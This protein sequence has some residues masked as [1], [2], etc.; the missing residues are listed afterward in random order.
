MSPIISRIVADLKNMPDAPSVNDALLDAAFLFEKARGM[1][2]SG[3]SDEV[4]AASPDPEEMRLLQ[5]SVVD[6]VERTGV[7]SWTLGKCRDASLKPVLLAV[8]RRQLRGDAGELFQAMIALDNIGEPVFGSSS[9]YSIL[10]E[11]E[12]RKLAEE[13]LRVTI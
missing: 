10:D 12:N 9:S 5:R 3:W 13:Y 2:P 1:A 7:G 8:L 11:A 6:F 4:V